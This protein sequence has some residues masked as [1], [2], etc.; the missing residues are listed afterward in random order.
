[1]T[2]TDKNTDERMYLLQHLVSQKDSILKASQEIEDCFYQYRVAKKSDPDGKL[3]AEVWK[4]I[5]TIL[6]ALSD[7]VPYSSANKNIMKL[8]IVQLNAFETLDWIMDS[9]F[10]R[11]F[12][13]LANG[14]QVHW[15]MRKGP[16]VTFGDVSLFKSLLGGIAK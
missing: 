3:K 5:H 11:L 1:M 4:R 10:T 7:L 15:D 8:F 12:L 13:M 16:I 9:G 2:S 14:I 6:S